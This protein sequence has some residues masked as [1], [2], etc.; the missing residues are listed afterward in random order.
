MAFDTKKIILILLI[1]VV[2]LSGCITTDRFN[3]QINKPI[4]EKDLKKDVDFAEHKLEKLEPDLYH[5]ISKKKLEYR[6]DSLKATLNAPMTSKEFYFR[7]SP[8]IASIRQ[9]H[10][11]TFPLTKRLKHAERITAKSKGLTPLAQYEYE[12]FDN[13]LYIVK[14]NSDNPRIKPGTEVLSVNGVK[15]LEIISKYRNTFT[16]DGYNT[17]FITRKLG[18]SF[19]RFFYY[20]YGLTDSV[21]CKLN[22]KDTIRSVMLYRLEKTKKTALKKT[23]DEIVKDKKEQVAESRKRK[24]LGYDPLRRIYSKML[25]FPVK[26]SSVAVMKI[27]DFMK[28]NY[29]KFYKQSFRLMDSLHTKTLILDVRDNGGGLV[30]DINNL[31]SYLAD[32]SF[33]LVEKSEV[34]SRTSLWHFGYYHNMPCWVQA[35][36]TIFLPIVAGIDAFTFLKV[37][38]GTDHKYYYAFRDSKLTKPQPN[39]FKG[40]VYVLI[41]GGCFS[42]TCL[43][44]SN[45][46]GS[47]RE[48]FVGEE[49]GGSYNGCVAGILPVSTLPASKLGVRYGLMSIKTPYTSELDGRG[50]FPDV[51]IEPTIEDRMEGNDLELQWILNDIKGLK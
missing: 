37:R 40:K 46:K 43:L 13:R 19:A 34:T 23:K 22:Y 21:T 1:P 11:Q 18:T 25:T 27:S 45:L 42:A 50:I 16:S 49:T 2:L 7:L 31:Y 4:N 6:F 41:N 35:V 28:G 44:S 20:Q 15:P 48:T 26:D 17:T 30:H 14:N 33:H 24:L 12:Q 29:K 38:K 36:Q 3:A 32:S 10:T 9:G 47:K 8:V 5:F 39:R 51:E